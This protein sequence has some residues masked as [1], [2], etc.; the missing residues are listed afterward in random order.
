MT[1]VARRPNKP[2]ISYVALARGGSGPLRFGLWR[3]FGG[4]AILNC[5]SAKLRHL[6]AWGSLGALNWHGLVLVPVFH[7]ERGAR[8]TSVVAALFVRVIQQDPG[9]YALTQLL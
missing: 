4:N 2:L 9:L 7:A 6:F 5:A 1:R 3:A 8:L